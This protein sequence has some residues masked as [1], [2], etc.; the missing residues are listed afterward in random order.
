MGAVTLR[1]APRVL[2][3]VL[4]FSGIIIEIT[5]LTRLWLVVSMCCVEVALVNA[6]SDDYDFR[7]RIHSFCTVV[8]AMSRSASRPGKPRLL[9]L[10]RHV[11][12]FVNTLHD[13]VFAVYDAQ[14]RRAGAQ[15]PTPTRFDSEPERAGSLITIAAHS[16][17]A[18]APVDGQPLD[19]PMLV[20]ETVDEYVFGRVGPLLLHAF[21]R[22]NVTRDVAYHT[23]LSALRGT[24][25]ASPYASSSQSRTAPTSPHHCVYHPVTTVCMSDTG[26]QP[27]HMGIGSAVV[28]ADVAPSEYLPMNDGDDSGPAGPV[29]PVASKRA[30][31]ASPTTPVAPPP[32]LHPLLPTP[33]IRA[34]ASHMHLQ[35]TT[36]PA[37]SEPP[38]PP[39]QDTPRK[40]IV[41]GSSP[42][43]T[44]TPAPPP[45]SG[46]S[47]TVAS[48]NPSLIP[49]SAAKW[50]AAI[51]AASPAYTRPRT[52]SSFAL[53]S[54]ATPASRYALG[55]RSG[56]VF[57]FRVRRVTLCTTIGDH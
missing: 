22:D 9:T 34:A 7:S 21:K 3:Q 56:F 41:M 54:T 17:T 47:A 4:L 14:R 15:G 26:V 42:D 13:Q 11:K 36:D 45:P 32:L 51:A 35:I 52:V 5:E 50:L 19:L 39:V 20:V 16:L 25:V 30:E 48:T 33:Q 6:R 29:T 38:P 43:V 10:I 24:C 27:Y 37:P 23:Q 2:F 49:T 53:S 57:E 44:T 12:T 1:D 18:T 31:V 28:N 8:T 46:P 40:F 55:T